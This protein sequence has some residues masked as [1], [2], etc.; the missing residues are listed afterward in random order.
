MLLFKDSLRLFEVYNDGILNLLDKYF[1]M[2]RNQ[3]KESLDIYIKFLGRKSKL[4]EFLE[5]AQQVGVSQD[6]IPHLTKA[7]HSLLEALQHHLDSME[8]K[9]TPSPH[10]NL[11][12]AAVTASPHK[13]SLADLNLGKIPAKGFDMNQP[14]ETERNAGMNC[15]LNT[16]ICMPA[17]GNLTRDYSS[18][19]MVL[20]SVTYP[21]ICER[22][23]MYRMVPSPMGAPYRTSEPT[24]CT[25]LYLRTTYSSCS[26]PGYSSSADELESPVPG[27]LIEFEY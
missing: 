3:C 7:P 18:P 15:Q 21:L 25:Q 23:P 24:I 13:D 12:S 1:D 10:H 5:V 14:L 27:C 17:T 20:P 26:P 19:Y 16:N 11:Q 2:R 4:A 22:V 8:V 9:V 6:A